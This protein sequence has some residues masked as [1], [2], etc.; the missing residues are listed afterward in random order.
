[1]KLI[2]RQ[3]ANAINELI[4]AINEPINIKGKIKVK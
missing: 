2:N 3:Q 1:M 4:K